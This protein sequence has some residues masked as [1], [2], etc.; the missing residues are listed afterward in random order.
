VPRACVFL[1][2]GTLSFIF[3]STLLSRSRSHCDHIQVYDYYYHY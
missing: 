1:M 3:Y 2:C